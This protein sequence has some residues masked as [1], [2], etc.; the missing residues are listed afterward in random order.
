MSTDDPWPGL[1]LRHLVAL[2]AVAA[3]ES[4]RAA[5]VALGFTQ[6][7]LSQQ[8]ATLER[9]IGKRLID[10]HPG[11]RR[12]QPTAD[13]Q[14]LLQHADAILDRVVAAR[15]ALGGEPGEQVIR[16]G[17]LDSVI[18]V[19]FAGAVARLLLLETPVSLEVSDD[20]TSDRLLERV[21]AKEIDLAV[22]DDDPPSDL[23]ASEP[24]LIDPYV[25][26]VAWDSEL[27]AEDLLPLER[28]VQLP[29]YTYSREC[30]VTTARLEE[31]ATSLGFTLSIVLRSCEPD[32][33]RRLVE[34]AGGCALLPQLAVTKSSASVCVPIDQRLPPRLIRVVW[35][36]GSRLTAVAELF[37]GGLRD[38]FAVGDQRG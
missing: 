6:G 37:V 35:R 31:V 8:I 29:L 5:A 34:D 10:R 25:A 14:L 13:G 22:I 28:L 18:R 20:R 7:A 11:A 24:L 4:F 23:F 16:V 2:R 33:L 21:A 12:V 19:L 1:E 17:A 15:S 36:R 32:F 27:A 26:L 3:H 38:S 9:R 30:S